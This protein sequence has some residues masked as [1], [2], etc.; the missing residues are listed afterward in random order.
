MNNSLRLR[1]ILGLCIVPYSGTI[2]SQTFKTG[3]DSPLDG[4][5]NAIAVNGTTAYFG[6]TFT[7]VGYVC[8]TGVLLDTS[9]A[10]PVRTFAKFFDPSDGR[11]LVA[12]SDNM[13]GVYAGGQ[14]TYVNGQQRKYLAHIRADG[15]LDPWNPSPSSFV[16]TLGLQGNHLYVGGYFTTIAG[17]SRGYAAAFDTT[18]GSLL[19]WDPEANNFVIAL[20]PVGTVVYLGGYFS[21]LNT[22][23]RYTIGSVDSDSGAATSWNPNPAV[24]GAGVYQFLHYGSYIYA[25][26]SFAQIDGVTRYGIVKLDLSGNVVAGWRPDTGMVGSGVVCLAAA[27]NSI[28]AGGSYSKLGGVSRNNLAAIDVAT[29]LVTSWNPN[30]SGNVSNNVTALAFDGS[31]L[32]VGG[33]FGNIGGQARSYFAAVDTGTGTA[34]AWN[35]NIDEVPLA[36][37]VQNGCVFAGGRFSS[38]N[39][40]ARSRIAAIDLGS[41]KMTAWNPNAGGSVDALAYSGGRVY[42]GGEFTSIGGGSH[43]YIAALDTSLGSAVSWSGTAN[44]YVYALMVMGNRLYAAGYFTTMNGQSHNSVAALDLA[45]GAV[46]TWS[47]TFDNSGISALAYLGDTVYVGGNFNHVNS[48]ARSYGAAFDTTTGALTAWSP[49][50]DNM[51][52]ALAVKDTAVYVGGTLYGTGGQKS[53]VCVSGATGAVDTLFNAHFTLAYNVAAIVPAGNE[54]YISGNFSTINSL[55]RPYLATLDPSTG[56]VSTWN[57]AIQGGPIQCIAITG[58]TVLA[59]GFLGSILDWP[60]KQLIQLSDTSINGGPLPVELTTFQALVE[61]RDVKLFWNT[62][63]E[64]ES[65]GFEVERREAG[66]NQNNP[67]TDIGLVRGAGSSSSPH[68]Y[69]FVD[70]PPASRIDYRLK[71]MNQDGSFRFSPSVEVQFGSIPAT[72]SLAQNY[73]NPFNPTTVISFQ[74][75]VTSRTTLRI[76]DVLGREVVTLVDEVRPAG[77]YTLRWDAAQN[78]SGI[79]FYRLQAGNFT[80]TKKLVLL[81]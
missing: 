46:K 72:Y 25:C 12:I 73:P 60:Q 13:G 22:D 50:L 76:Y 7:K 4:Q 69:S 23:S 61:K 21:D 2:L 42:A 67:W 64:T 32:W 34:S 30:P 74:L 81:K 1:F 44:S 66:A 24:S 38:V 78:S 53:I 20:L 56:A 41:G 75:P 47:P 15:S 80:A 37:V 77:T 62:A 28:I 31:Q 57:S 65:Y 5:I 79:Y 55:S 17:Q 48:I 54:L 19:P 58:Q 26:G 3:Y 18:T 49:P 43:G 40:T 45:S 68:Q 29:G 35:A 10:Q 14:F 52:N 71:F 33:F 39:A 70:T 59:G 6:G 16:Y 51:P 36:L 11:I 27:G 9:T 8:G 63:S